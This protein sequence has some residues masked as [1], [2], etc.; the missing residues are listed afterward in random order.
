MTLR[1]QNGTDVSWPAH[2]GSPGAVEPTFLSPILV[3]DSMGLTILSRGFPRS[4]TSRFRWVLKEWL[5]SCLNSGIGKLAGPR[6]MADEPG[7]ALEM[8]SGPFRR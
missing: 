2:Y 5:R 1:S 7:K 4:S 8:I 3:M 6:D